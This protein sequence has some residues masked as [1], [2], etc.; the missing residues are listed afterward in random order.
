VEEEVDEVGRPW[1]FR[2]VRPALESRQS[3]LAFKLRGIRFAVVG[4]FPD[5]TSLG[6]NHGP[7]SKLPTSDAEE[8]LESRFSSMCDAKSSCISHASQPLHFKEAGK[9][10]RSDGASY[11]VVALCPIQ[12]PACK[13]APEFT[14]RV[15]I[16]IESAE[17]V[18]PCMRDHECVFPKKERS[19]SQEL[20][21]QCNRKHTCEVVIAGPGETHFG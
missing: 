9:Q 12:A 14:Q 19:T 2:A 5:C 13:G 4:Q 7:D 18:L 11:V 16:D 21:S 8:A 1:Q 15:N 20:V 3:P 17:K 6:N 10:R